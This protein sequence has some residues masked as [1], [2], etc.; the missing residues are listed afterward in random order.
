MDLS[1]IAQRFPLVARPRPVCRPLAQRIQEVEDLARAARQERSLANAS[2]TMNRA[3]LIASDC[4][5]PG[6]AR[7]LCWQHADTYLASCPLGAQEARYALE[8]LVNLARLAIRDG[9]GHTAY[10][11]LESLLDAAQRG[12]TANVEGRDVPLDGLTTDVYARQVVV[13]W[14]WTVLLGDGTRALVA[15]RDWTR[16][17]DHVV[18]HNGVGKRLLDGRQITVVA[19]CMNGDPLQGRQLLTDS[20]ITDPWEQLTAAALGGLCTVAAGQPP[21]EDVRQ[22]TDLY[23]ATSPAPEQAVFHTRI[24]LTAVDLA[25]ATASPEAEEICALVTGHAVKS[26]DAYVAREALAHPETQDRMTRS[27]QQNLT[28]LVN[29]SGLGQGT[30]PPPLLRRLTEAVDASEAEIGRL[31]STNWPE[32]AR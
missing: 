1:Q 4:G 32:D 5:L 7:T 10:R 11:I 19:H 14:L 15:T 30:M 31:L 6:L 23:R 21:H 18:R 13:K 12:T 16:V 28:D 3:A 20:T 22:V 24:G 2:A 8:P 27:D 26:G 25:L 17:R 9:N 29:A